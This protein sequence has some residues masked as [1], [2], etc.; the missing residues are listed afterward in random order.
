METLSSPEQKKILRQ[1]Q[2][3]SSPSW[4]DSYKRR[5]LEN[6]RKSRENFVRK[7]RSA[8]L[9]TKNSQPTVDDVMTEEWNRL[10]K[11]HSELPTCTE[12]LFS[13]D[14]EVRYINSIMEEIQAALK[15]EEES[16][17]EMYTED[18]EA[19]LCASIDQLGSNRVICPVCKKFTLF[20]N[21]HVVFCKCGIRIN[22]EEDALTLEDVK[23]SIERAVDI[24]EKACEQTAVFSTVQ[25]YGI[26]N[27]LMT[28]NVCD[29]MHIVV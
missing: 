13:T 14:D 9:D 20:M 8:S 7:F 17:L 27:L 3:K 16:L 19:S 28:C 25:M 11:D 2:Y 5:C 26:D 15:T 29:Y 1:N 4:R 10:R 23:L 22:T 12:L 21:K 18:Y 24:H 6:L